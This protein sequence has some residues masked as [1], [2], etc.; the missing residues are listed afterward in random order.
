MQDRTHII[1]V[2]WCNDCGSFLYGYIFRDK[3]SKAIVARC[4]EEEY[5]MVVK[6]LTEQGYMVAA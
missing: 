3:E 2:Q 4:D 1:T 6:E 5:Q